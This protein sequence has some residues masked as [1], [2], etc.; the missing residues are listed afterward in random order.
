MTGKI[1]IKQTTKMK[2]NESKIIRRK[3]K[4]FKVRKK[5][6]NKTTK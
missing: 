1:V 4:E 2:K 6:K 3:K 5:I